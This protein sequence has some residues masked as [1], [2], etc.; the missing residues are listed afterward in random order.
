MDTR[1]TALVTGASSGIGAELARLLAQGRHDL[2]LV[3]RQT[4]RLEELAQD[5]R[6]RFGIRATVMSKDL[7]APAAAEEVYAQVQRE[8]IQVDVL[9]NNAGFAVY[10]LFAGN[11]LESELQMIQVNLVA[12]TSLTKLFLRGMVERGHGKILNVGST[13]SFEPVPLASVYG[14]T[15]AYILSFSEA[16]AEELRGTGVTV[17][18]LCPG[19]TATEFAA[20]ADLAGARLFRSGVMSAREVALVGYRALMR[21]QTTVVAGLANKALIFSLRLAP[22]AAVARIAGWMM[23]GKKP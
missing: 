4:R 23:S 19:A 5:L 8:G 3:A 20:R 14:A 13:G 6:Q 1:R 9:V 17:T 18:A 10:G 15:K 2:V 7:S 22:R 12:L 21:G 16:I 11:S